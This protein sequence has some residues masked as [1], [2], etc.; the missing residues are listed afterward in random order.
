VSL[1]IQAVAFWYVRRGSSI[2]RSVVI[3]FF[4]L[5]ALPLAIVPRLVTER[6]VY[7]GGYLVVGFVL[8]G[9]AVWLLFTGA[10]ADWFVPTRGSND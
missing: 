1:G 6:A 5:A 3:V 9:V 10:A 7:S 4:V 8:K 2:A